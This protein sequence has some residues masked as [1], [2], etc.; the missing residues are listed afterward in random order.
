[1]D[2]RDFLAIVNGVRRIEAPSELDMP[3]RDTVLDS[4]DLA[5]LRSALEVRLDRPIPD[6]VWQGSAT[7]RQLLDALP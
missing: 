1:M 7:L 4:L 2:E 3:V 6:D 5:A